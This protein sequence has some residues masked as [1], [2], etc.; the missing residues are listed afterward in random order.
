MND[1]SAAVMIIVVFL[2]I[3]ILF[4]CNPETHWADQVERQFLHDQRTRYAAS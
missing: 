4:F 2:V 1:L 3:T